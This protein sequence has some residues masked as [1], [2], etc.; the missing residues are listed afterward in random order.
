MEVR[1]REREEQNVLP[2]NSLITIYMQSS[3][4]LVKVEDYLFKKFNLVAWS[5]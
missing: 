3:S 1:K 2:C 4:L 5:C